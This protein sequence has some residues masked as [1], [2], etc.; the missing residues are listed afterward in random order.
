MNPKRII[1]VGTMALSISISA[2]LWN[3]EANANAQIPFNP[4]GSIIDDRNEQ[5]NDKNDFLKVLG[6]STDEDVYY[7]LLDGKSLADIAEENQGSVADIIDLQ[8]AQLTE[9]LEQRL[10]NGSLEPAAY[11]MQKAEVATMIKKS[12]YGEKNT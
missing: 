1:I 6:A 11:H 3:K 12:V 9:Q 4:L 2:G 7:S 8:I 10:A 5:A